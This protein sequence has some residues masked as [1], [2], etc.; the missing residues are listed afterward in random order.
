MSKFWKLVWKCGPIF[1]G[2]MYSVRVLYLNCCKEKSHF[3]SDDSYRN[4]LKSSVRCNLK[5]V[6]SSTEYLLKSLNWRCKLIWLY[7]ILRLPI[8]FL[9]S[10]RKEKIHFVFLFCYRYYPVLI[11]C[12]FHP[13]FSSREVIG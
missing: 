4:T 5:K 8:I 13:V 1:S 3:L 2:T 12:S 10:D 11:P 9:V 7:T 6:T